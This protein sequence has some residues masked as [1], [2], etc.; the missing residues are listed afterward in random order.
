M[1]W[2][3]IVFVLLIL[4][5]VN[6]VSFDCQKVQVVDEKVIC[7]YLMLNDKD[8]EMYIKYQFLKGLFVM[9]SCGVLQDVQQSWFKQC[10]QCKVDVICLIKVYNECLK[11]FDVIYD[12][13]DKLF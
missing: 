1:K 11:Q 5:F 9:G 6:V 13:I 8:V 2:F 4:L 7:V 10:Q 12:Y 3:F